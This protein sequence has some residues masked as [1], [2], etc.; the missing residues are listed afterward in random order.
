MQVSN[1]S[2][3]VTIS[4]GTY[5]D[6]DGANVSFTYVLYIQPAQSMIVN[7]YVFRYSHL[8]RPPIHAKKEAVHH[9]NISSNLG[10][11][12]RRLSLTG[13]M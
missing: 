1:Y 12:G 6:D 7:I 4:Y 10:V 11:G 2:I 8:P 13:I 3:I 5:G 9:K